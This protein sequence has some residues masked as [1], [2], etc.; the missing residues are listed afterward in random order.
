MLAVSSNPKTLDFGEPSQIT[1][2][3]IGFGQRIPAM[4]DA[5]V[6]PSLG[7]VTDPKNEADV[8]AVFADRRSATGIDIQ[9]GHS[10]NRGKSWQFVKVNNDTGTA[11]HFNPSIT[12]DAV[13]NANVGF[14]DTRFSSTSQTAHVFLARSLGAETPF[15]NQRLTTALMNDSLT[16]PT[17]DTTANLGSHTGI[18]MM[19]GEVLIAWTDTRNGSEDIFASSVFEPAG[20]SITGNGT[21]NFAAGSYTGNASVSGK[22]EFGFTAGYRKRSS[23]PEGSMEFKFQSGKTKFKFTNDSDQSLIV[24]GSTA[25]LA[26]TGTVNDAS[27]YTF[28]LTVS[29]GD[30]SGTGIDKLR[31][32][33]KDQAGNVIFDNASGSPDVMN[34]TVLQ[35]ITNGRIEIRN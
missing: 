19:N 10:R 12:M 30:K 6:G 2:T 29:D 22:A 7:L 1:T 20:Q 24:S 21:I 35:P 31:I 32:K 28:V 16:N 26:G 17:R 4:P 9:F 25:M 14:Y 27:G 11:D 33:I 13:G 15:D 23:V 18:A 34:D 5:G 3:S 8:Y